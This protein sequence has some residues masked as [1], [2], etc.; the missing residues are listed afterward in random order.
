MKSVIIQNQLF[1]RC[2][3][4]S[5]LNEVVNSYGLRNVDD[6]RWFSRETMKETKTVEHMQ[7]ISKK[8][9]DYYLPCKARN[10]LFIITDKICITILRQILREFGYSLFS[11]ETYRKKK[12]QILYQ[13]YS[14]EQIEMVKSSSR[15]A[16]PLNDTNC[17]KPTIPSIKIEH[18]P[19]YVISFS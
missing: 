10:Y 1:R 12:K 9:I 15:P 13:I 18:N 14:N 3:P 5:L 6:T 16:S 4:S 7:T 8:L 19:D 17:V 11:K 2:I